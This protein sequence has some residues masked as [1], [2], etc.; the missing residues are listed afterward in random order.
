MNIYINLHSSMANLNKFNLS[1]LLNS[2]VHF[3]YKHFTL[4]QLIL[5]NFN[6]NKNLFEIFNYF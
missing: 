2:I 5:I 3:A 6:S 1:F 4:I